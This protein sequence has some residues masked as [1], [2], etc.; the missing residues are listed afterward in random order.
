MSTIGRRIWKGEVVYSREKLLPSL[1]NKKKQLTFLTS[2]SL[3]CIKQNSSKK[4]WN[5]HI[6]RCQLI[7]VLCGRA[8]WAEGSV[9]NLSKD[10]GETAAR[11]EASYR[12]S[13]KILKN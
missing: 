5:L 12:R 4:L 2:T 8:T 6:I 11:D 9:R 1:K 3:R 7:I 10:D 13:S